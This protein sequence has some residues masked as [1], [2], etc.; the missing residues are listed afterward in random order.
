[1][2]ERE[3]PWTIIIEDTVYTQDE[4][5]RMSLADLKMLCSFLDSVRKLTKLSNLANNDALSA[6]IFNL[7]AK[8]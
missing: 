2:I 6:Y 5:R 4:L 7:I 3:T 8:L 1:M